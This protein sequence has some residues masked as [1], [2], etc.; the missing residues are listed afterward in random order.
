MTEFT[1]KGPLD[2]AVSGTAGEDR[3]IYNLVSGPGGVVLSPLVHNPVSG[4]DGQFEPTDGDVTTFTGIE[5]FTFVDK[6]GGDDTITTG[7]GNDALNGRAG[8]DVLN[9]AGGSD[10][11]TGGKGRDTL[12]GGVESDTIEG[13]N[14]NDR[15]FGEAG[16][17]VL[18][19]GNGNDRIFGGID[20]DVMEGG[21]GNDRM[22]GGL[23]DD[24]IV[25]G[26]GDDQ[27]FGGKGI[28]FI[29]AD[30]GADV[31]DAGNGND[32]IETAFDTIKTLEGGDGRD[33]LMAFHHGT[34]TDKLTFNLS[35]GNFGSTDANID[36]STATNFE[37]F[38]FSGN[39]DTKITGTD[40]RNEI[41]GGFADDVLLGKG[42]MD[43]LM[44]DFGNDTLFGNR[45]ADVLDG[46]AGD[47][48]MTG[49][50]GADTFVFS[51]GSDTITDFRNDV[52]AIHIRSDLVADGT[53]AE[54]LISSATVIGGNTVITLDGG[55]T[56]TIDGLTDT[57]LLSDDMALI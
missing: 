41:I 24:F 26:A 6:V 49:G 7:D 13:G 37:D 34:T 21:D 25:G 19:G 20:G 5:H 57:S 47:D 52:D 54:D 11:I 18:Y 17:D 10:E 2:T 28:D 45:K 8:N 32:Q 9:G 38:V 27:I 31:V 22:F 3:L 51:G 15:L 55:D 56:L 40:G 42:G 50:F 48:T 29:I 53:T 23:G 12:Y 35:T 46:G 44:G 39:I 33:M 43:T 14:G 30:D 36:S 16:Y 1:V 4:F